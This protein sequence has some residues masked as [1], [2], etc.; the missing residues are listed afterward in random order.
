M[1]QWLLCLV[2]YFV[3]AIPTLLIMGRWLH[4]ISKNYPEVKEWEPQDRGNM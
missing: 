4:K 2:I 3:V 1:P